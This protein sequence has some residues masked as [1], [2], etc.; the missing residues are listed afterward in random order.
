MVH[1]RH[2]TNYCISNVATT[3]NPNLTVYTYTL[4]RVLWHVDAK[5]LN[6]LVT[7]N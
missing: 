7:Y 1:F 5:F 3:T 2:S 6:K 4:M